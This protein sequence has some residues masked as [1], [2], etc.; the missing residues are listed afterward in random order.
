MVLAM[1]FFRRRSARDEMSSDA[2]D[3]PPPLRPVHIVALVGVLALFA[4]STVPA[5]PYDFCDLCYLFSLED[6]RWTPQEWMHPLW[7]PFL[8]GYRWVLALFGFHGHMLVAVEVLNVGIALWALVL[9]FA[10]TRRVTRDPLIAIAAALVTAGCHAFWCAAVRPTPYA[11]AFTCLTASLVLLVSDD[12]VPTRRYA[13]AGAIAG[14]A[15]GLH[16]SAMSLGPAALICALREPDVEKTRARTVARTAAF[17][18]AMVAS[19]LTCWTLFIA[20]NHIARDY[21]QATQFATAFAGIEQVQG[22]SIYTSHNPLRQVIEFARTLFGKNDALSFVAV[23]MLVWALWQRRTA[24]PRDPAKPVE[25]RLATAALANLGVLG[26]F[27]LI[28]NTHNGF[29][30]ASL[31]LAPALIAVVASRLRNG[32]IVFLGLASVLAI[33]MAFVAKDRI[34]ATPGVVSRDPVLAEVQFLDARMRPKDVILTPGC[35]FPEMQYLTPLNLVELRSSGV[36]A[37]SCQVPYACV[38]RTLRDRG[39]WWTTHGSRV[40]MA[41][42]DETT[43]FTSDEDWGEKRRQIF[44]DPW[45]TASERA[46]HL[47]SVRSAMEAAGLL[48]GSVMLSPGG[49]RY[50]QVRPAETNGASVAPRPAASLTA[51]EL[52]AAIGDRDLVSRYRVRVLTQFARALPG[53]PWSVCDLM[54]LACELGLRRHGSPVCEPI[55]GCS[56]CAPPSAHAETGVSPATAVQAR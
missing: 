15:M 46:P 22:T 14:L 20:R 41:L 33:G 36:G 47:A 28:N 2:R 12:P 51:D 38:D 6:G 19:A 13:I 11:L 18:A 3:Q 7:V 21:F 37:D 10:L 16:A 23:P 43:N 55:A 35:P 9:L 17:G 4:L 42:G 5:I 32:R 44:G 50:A 27:F 30:F 53:D 52:L 49:Q 40:F 26:A 1:L 54:Q 24:T 56:A 29:V 8:D 48:I 34:V 39:D 25:Q 45:L 31:A